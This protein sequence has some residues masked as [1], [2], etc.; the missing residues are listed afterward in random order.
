MTGKP[1][2]PD[3]NQYGL[4][5]KNAQAVDVYANRPGGE[6]PGAGPADLVDASGH[7]L[8]EIEKHP[9]QKPSSRAG[10]A[11]IHEIDDKKR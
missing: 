9:L 5:D 4:K 10:Q 8:G 3:Y 7:R 1:T 11:V 6:Q 2:P